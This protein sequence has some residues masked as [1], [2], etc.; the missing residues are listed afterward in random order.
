MPFFWPPLRPVRQPV[1][2]AKRLHDARLHEARALVGLLLL[3]RLLLLLR[4]LPLELF[5]LGLE[6]ER[7]GELDVLQLLALLALRLLATIG[8]ELQLGATV[9]APPWSVEPRLVVLVVLG[10]VGR[11]HLGPG[12]RFAVE[13]HVPL[14]GASPRPPWVEWLV[15]VARLLVV[16]PLLHPLLLPA[17]PA[18]LRVGPRVFLRSRLAPRFGVVPLHRV[19]L[20]PRLD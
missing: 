3:V 13:P 5:P 19:D 11:L 8:A 9:L 4:L 10:H 2:G 20:R 16:R 1:L 12:R 6:F 14:P 18:N 7:L 17:R 15:E